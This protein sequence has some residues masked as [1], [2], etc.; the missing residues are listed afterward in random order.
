ML[1]QE[2]ITE[3]ARL[4]AAT[5]TASEA[6]ARHR[7]HWTLDE[8]NRDRVTIRAYAKA[9]GRSKSMVYSY[10]NGYARWEADRTRT[11]SLTE[12]GVGQRSLAD[13]IA[14]ADMS[15]EKEAVVEAVAKA[16]GVGIRTVRD[17]RSTEVAR[18]REAAR[19]QAERKG[20]T[21]EHEAARM[22]E[23]AANVEKNRAARN[24]ERAADR[25]DR[26]GLDYWQL[27]GTLHK[28]KKILTDALAQAR[29][30]DW[31]EEHQELLADTLNGVKAL[32]GLI[33]L[34]VTG[35]ADV[36]WDAELEALSTT[37][38]DDR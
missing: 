2:V 32:L 5:T 11:D 25:R 13:A 6:L 23:W 10:A 12:D 22:A 17:T 20:T 14:L 16:R 24:A 30:I 36:D 34:A 21:V 31:E 8:T 38:E 33:D 27:E 4:E 35:T 9:I 29:A 7:W 28:A 15:A 26:L 19:E 1:P 3:D 37:K 18:I